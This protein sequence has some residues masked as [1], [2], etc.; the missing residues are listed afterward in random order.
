M[1]ISFDPE[2]D[3]L[4]ARLQEGKQVCRTLRLNEEPPRRLRESVA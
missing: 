3:A 1:K 4:Y 2:N